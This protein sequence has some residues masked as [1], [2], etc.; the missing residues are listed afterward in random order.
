MEK[1]EFRNHVEMVKRARELFTEDYVLSFKYDC[2]S[3][4][5]YY[6]HP[7]DSNQ[8]CLIGRLFYGHIPEDHDFW[9][10]GDAI[11]D[12]MN[13]ESDES[14][15]YVLVRAFPWM[16]PSF[17]YKLQNQIHDNACDEGRCVAGEYAN[18][19]KWDHYLSEAEELDR[20][21]KLT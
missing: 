13:D 20:I 21:Y 1:V 2:G 5:C 14:N 12:I 19:V 3:T 6:R 9:Y 10:S 15:G 4:T 17:V 8:R 7:E 11:D 18:E 16:N